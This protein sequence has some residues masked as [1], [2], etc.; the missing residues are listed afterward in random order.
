MRSQRLGRPPNPCHRL[1]RPS[2]RR[3]RALDRSPGAHR[4]P[5]QPPR[6]TALAVGAT[7]SSPT[8]SRLSPP[9]PGCGHPESRLPAAF[10]VKRKSTDRRFWRGTSR[11]KPSL[12]AVFGAGPG[13]KAR[14]AGAELS[15]MRATPTTCSVCS[16]LCKN[17]SS[18]GYPRSPPTDYQHPDRPP[19]R[20]TMSATANSNCWPR[21]MTPAPGVA[22]GGVPRTFAPGVVLHWAAVGRTLPLRAVP[23]ADHRRPVRRRT[24]SSRRRA[25][26]CRARR[27]R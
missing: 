20:S 4:R 15:W 1:R 9:R 19:A 3:C 17:P 27:R 8:A 22:A 25:L 10:V 2:R 16:T 11:G 12:A 24:L 14:A 26:P 21:R 6:L 5:P 13:T 7:G 18:P 23:P